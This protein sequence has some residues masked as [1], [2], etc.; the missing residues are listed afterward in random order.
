MQKDEN[1]QNLKQQ[2]KRQLEQNMSMEQINRKLSQKHQNQDSHLLCSNKQTLGQEFA[3]DFEITIRDTGV[4]IKPE[5][6]PKL[7]LDFGKLN[8][9]EGRN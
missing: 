9:S 2:I 3:I 4:G 8:D 6:L 5:D 1:R 7:F